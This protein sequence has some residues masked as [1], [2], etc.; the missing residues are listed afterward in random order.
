MPRAQQ[1]PARPYQE[2]STPVPT[3]VELRTDASDV[4]D[5]LVHHDQQHATSTTGNIPGGLEDG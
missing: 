3:D 2:T 1:L 4:A 5:Q